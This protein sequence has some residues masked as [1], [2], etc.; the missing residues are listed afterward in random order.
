ME[1]NADLGTTRTAVP[2]R[3]RPRSRSTPQAPSRASTRRLSKAKIQRISDHGPPTA[4]PAVQAPQ[5]R[6]PR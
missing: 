4:R 2:D 5:V 3:G 6:P 1:W